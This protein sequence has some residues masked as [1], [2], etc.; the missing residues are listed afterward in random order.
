MP[1]SCSFGFVARHTRNFPSS[2]I[3][4]VHCST[5]TLV[6][7]SW[8]WSGWQHTYTRISVDLVCRNISQR[9]LTLNYATNWDGYCLTRV[10]WIIHVVDL[11]SP[12]LWLKF[13]TWI[14]AETSNTRCDHIFPRYRTDAGLLYCSLL[15]R[16]LRFPPPILFVTHS[17]AESLKNQESTENAR[18]VTRKVEKPAIL[19]FKCSFNEQDGGCIG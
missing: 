11:I 8:N 5:L 12:F 13:A 15:R 17:T 3:D 4:G 16:F 10:R 6:P 14:L 9:S 18:I 2:S 7:S 19:K 1:A